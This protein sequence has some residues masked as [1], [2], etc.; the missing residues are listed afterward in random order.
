MDVEQF[1]L[2]VLL[3]QTHQ[4]LLELPF[5]GNK[6]GDH[7]DRHRTADGAGRREID[8]EDVRRAHQCLA[9][10]AVTDVEIADADL[11]V[12]RVGGKIAPEGFARRFIFIS[13]V[14][15][16]RKETV[17]GKLR[18]D[19]AEA[20]LVATEPGVIG[21]VFVTEGQMVAEGA[22]VLSIRT[23]R[24]MSD[25]SVL[26]EA[27]TETLQRER[28]SLAE[29]LS[30]LEESTRLS[31]EAAGLTRD[32]AIRRIRELIAQRELI[33][34]RL[35]VSERRREEIVGLREK[36][37]VA[38][39]VYNEREEAVVALRQ[40]LIQIDGQIGDARSRRT[41]A[42]TELRQIGAALDRD[43]AALDQRLAQT[44][45]QIGQI[46]SGA[47]Q[48]LH[49]SQSG[50]IAALKARAG[51]QAEPGT[52]LAV[53][54]P[55]DAELFVEVYLPSRA[56]GFVEDGQI[57]RLMYDAFPYQKFGLA[58]GTISSVSPIALRPDEVG[59]ATQSPELLYR[60]KIKLDQQTLT[61]F[62]KPVPLQAGMELSADIILEER[63][64]ID[65][66][67]E[68]LRSIRA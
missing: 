42:E 41:Q 19:A 12:E 32:D 27:L 6:R 35:E 31:S 4:T 53:I 64:V 57:V 51:E 26:S 62:G 28:V 17:R 23:Q 25:G 10:R 8:N 66:L 13:T 58:R 3:K 56:A 1:E 20:K 38:E 65:W 43:R 36:G 30:A 46:E 54:L 67:L 40:S 63:R 34:E 37:L 60:V 21:E 11:G 5:V 29:Q 15:F 22:P 9:E 47:E 48:V 33:A 39:P 49:A 61:A 59:I 50:R 52:P 18:F 55:A 24:F 16:A 45:A 2:D 44:D 68:P 14:S 7:A